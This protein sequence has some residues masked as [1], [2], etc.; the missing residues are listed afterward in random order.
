MNNPRGDPDRYS[1]KRCDRPDCGRPFDLPFWHLRHAQRLGVSHRR[2][3]RLGSGSAGDGTPMEPQLVLLKIRMAGKS[4]SE[5][6]KS[7]KTEFPRLPVIVL[8]IY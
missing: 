7:L 1:A 6:L 3:G 2:R 5:T 8:T 4:G